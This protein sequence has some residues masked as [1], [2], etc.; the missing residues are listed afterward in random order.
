MT[1][2]GVLLGAPAGV[3][4]AAP[5]DVPI[6]IANNGFEAPEREDFSGVQVTTLPGWAVSGYVVHWGA[7]ATF[8]SGS[9]Y[10]ALGFTSAEGPVNGTVSQPLDGAD[11]AGATVTFEVVAQGSGEISLGEQ[12]EAITGSPSQPTTREVTFVV[13]ASAPADLLLA[14]RS[15]VTWE[16][17]QITGIY[18]AEC[19]TPPTATD[20]T[21]ATFD[22]ATVTVPVLANDT[23]PDGDPLTVTQVTDP[24][25]GT[26]V[27]NADGT[28]DYTPDPGFLGTDS[29]DYTVSDGTDTDTATVTVQVTELIPS[30]CTITGTAG[31]DVLRGTSG[32]DVICG[33]GGNDTITANAGNDTVYGGSGND[34]IEGGSGNDVIVGGSGSD[35]VAGGSGAD[36]LLVLDLVEANDS[37]NGGS[38][39]DTCAGDPR[40][41]LISCA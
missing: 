31:N 38:G 40:D 4:H 9:Q 39:N 22:G 14:L 7:S 17:D 41:V 27:S 30:G 20:D 37:A 35:D 18:V 13:P 24:P 36:N 26:A 29:F 3:A 2:G 1:A 15:T 10:V 16:V 34:T 32:A 28:V 33:L 5:C 12:V 19:N 11:L 21:A 8:P 23:D 25:N 6:V